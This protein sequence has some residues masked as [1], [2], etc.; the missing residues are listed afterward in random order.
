MWRLQPSGTQ[1]QQSIEAVMVA[2]T[3]AVGQHA[4]L[5]IEQDSDLIIGDGRLLVPQELHQPKVCW[6]RVA[7]APRRPRYPNLI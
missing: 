4:G 3:N 7:A 2:S 6:M 5:G 1:P